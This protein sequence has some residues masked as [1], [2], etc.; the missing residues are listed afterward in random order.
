[1][2]VMAAQFRGGV[3]CWLVEGSSRCGTGG[4]E[5]EKEEGVIRVSLFTEILSCVL[6][7]VLKQIKHGENDSLLSPV[8]TGEG[9]RFTVGW[10]GWDGMGA[11]EPNVSVFLA[12]T[13]WPHND[14]LLTR[15]PRE[16]ESDREDK[17]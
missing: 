12:S 8:T 11:L 17:E 6:S 2:T 14:K 3:R 1:M 15:R 16:L 9:G 5:A 4:K 7:L 13:Y 10:D